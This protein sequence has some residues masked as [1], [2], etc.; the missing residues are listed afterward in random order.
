MDARRVSSPQFRRRYSM[1]CRDC[2]LDANRRVVT[3]PSTVYHRASRWVCA[4]NQIQ[5]RVPTEFMT[6]RQPVWYFH[7][8]FALAPTPRAELC[9]RERRMN[10]HRLGVTG[11]MR[12]VRVID[13]D[14]DGVRKRVHVTEALARSLVGHRRIERTAPR[15]DRVNDPTLER[16]TTG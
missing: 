9:P 10:R 6:Q 1:L 8:V 16:D 15:N 5:M 12:P 3:G 11:S 2:V 14:G 4:N 7:A 13:L